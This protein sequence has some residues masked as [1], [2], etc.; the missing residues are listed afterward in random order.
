MDIIN[1]F[2]QFNTEGLKGNVNYDS[3]FCEQ[4][5]GEINS[6]QNSLEDL[7]ESVEKLAMQF[8]ENSK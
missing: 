1:D 4:E 6:C 7:M 5:L 2:R 3:G 8:A